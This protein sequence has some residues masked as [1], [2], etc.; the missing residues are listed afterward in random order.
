MDHRIRFVQVDE[1]W[2]VLRDTTGLL[3]VIGGRLNNG[4]L[5]GLYDGCY[6][7]ELVD[8]F[9]GVGGGERFVGDE[10]RP[11]CIGVQ[12]GGGWLIWWNDRRK[13]EHTR[14]ADGLIC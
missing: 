4:R 12:D 14:V 2:G 10:E 9:L 5:I 13:V 1:C 6:L 7:V 8:I 11:F 3:Y